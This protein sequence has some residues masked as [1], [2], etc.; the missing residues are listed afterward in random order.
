MGF[1]NVPFFSDGTRN[2]AEQGE[3]GRTTASEALEAVVGRRLRFVG[4]GQPR[5][6]AF[7]SGVIDGLLLV[8]RPHDLALGR[9]GFS[10][11]L[12][13]LPMA[14]EHGPRRVCVGH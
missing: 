4:R 14:P 10:N 6:K 8:A 7:F 12:F 1:S 13:F 2:T 5:R 11:A 9:T 3:Q